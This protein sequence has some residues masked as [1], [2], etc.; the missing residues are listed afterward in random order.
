MSKSLKRTSIILIALLIIV[1]LA[2]F[3]L[4]NKT[5]PQFQGI[6]NKPSSTPSLLRE[7]PPSDDNV[8]CSADV[9]QCPNGSYVSRVPPLCSFAP[10]PEDDKY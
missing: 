6:I 3:Y 5:A 4:K 7:E 9:K 1:L 8:R 2:T 10:C